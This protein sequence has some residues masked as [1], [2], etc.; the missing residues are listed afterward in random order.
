MR[1]APRRCRMKGTINQGAKRIFRV[2]L[3]LSVKYLE[4]HSDTP[5][6]KHRLA[7]NKL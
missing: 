3:G 7:L 4:M 1:V 6:Y 5:N 2:V